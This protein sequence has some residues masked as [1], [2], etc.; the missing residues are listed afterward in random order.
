MPDEGDGAQKRVA[1][2]ELKLT[3]MYK[4]LENKLK[5][6]YLITRMEDK[7]TCKEKQQKLVKVIITK[8]NTY[9]PGK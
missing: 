1:E 4:N 3:C 2:M 6:T 8:I 7:Q 9:I 5:N